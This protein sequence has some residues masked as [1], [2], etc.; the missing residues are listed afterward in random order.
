VF[1]RLLHH[2]NFRLADHPEVP[3]SGYPGGLNVTPINDV[4]IIPDP[5]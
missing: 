2:F 4:A 1:Q 5:Q 3:S